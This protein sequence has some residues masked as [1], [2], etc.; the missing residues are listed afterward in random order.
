MAYAFSMELQRSIACMCVDLYLGSIFL[1]I[2]LF[3]DDGGGGDGDGDDDGDVD[4]M[5]KKPR[6]SITFPG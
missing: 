2:D 6:V 4:A 5:R 1:P 3:V